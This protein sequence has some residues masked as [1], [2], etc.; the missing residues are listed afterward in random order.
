MNVDNTA[1]P[2]IK[3]RRKM[4]EKEMKE[5]L[6]NI[7]VIGMGNCGGQMAQAAAEKGFDAVAINASKKDL[8]LLPDSVS[9]FMVGDGRGTGKNRDD[10]RMF[11]NERI[12]MLQDDEI[13][14]F[15]ESHDAIVVA[16]SIG[17]GFGS[18]ASF[19]VYQ[20][21]SEM[22]P[23]K[24]IIIAGVF[25][26]SQESWTPHYHAI[27]WL[28][29]LDGMEASYL[30]Y[31][32]DR[33]SA[34]RGSNTADIMKQVNTQFAENLCVIRGDAIGL[35][36]TGGI[37]NRDMMTTLSVPGRIVIDTMS[38]DE[39]DVVDRNIAKT[40]L[41]HINKESAHAELVD[42]K[43][44]KVSAVMYTLRRNFA[45][46]TVELKADVQSVFGDHITDYDNF[47]DLDDASDEPDS[48]S[49][50]LSGLTSPTMRVNRLISNFQRME[51]NISSRKQ[52]T[53]K[54]GTVNTGSSSLGLKAKSFAATATPTKKAPDRAAILGKY[55]KS[56]ATK[57]TAM[58]DA[59]QAMKDVNDKM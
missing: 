54:L 24:A 4:E 9:K 43:E 32:N 53:S 26:F 12:N 29:E 23:D 2:I 39:S 17:G 55:A 7:G 15:I 50:I 13:V 40:V 57:E 37:D 18:G 27:G 21:L 5:V 56:V 11:M 44:I 48:I 35:T 59:I 42:D 14:R 30:L 22:Y 16:T 31:D 3:Y 49:V 46:Y 34:Q 1:K 25:P 38:L 33:L 51:N 45:P 20:L 8:D 58:A 47:A 36:T 10:A 19:V 41:E 6:I 28:Q 52:S